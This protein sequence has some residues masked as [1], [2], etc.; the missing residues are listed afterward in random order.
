MTRIA[1]MRHYPTDW[2]DEARLQGQ[3]DRPLTEAGR[4]RIAALSLPPEWAGA[5][6]ISSTLSRAVDTAELM[7]GR[8]PERE[9][10][11]VEIAWGDWEGARSEDLLKDPASGFVPTH[12]M[13]WDMRPP[14]GE[15]MRDA[16]ER[17]RPA[18]ADVAAAG[19]PA[20][21]VIHKALMRMLFGFAHNW[22]DAPEVKRGRIYPMS[23]RASG[24]PHAPEP[25]VPLIER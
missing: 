24:M 16:W 1:L 21:L 5:R 2:N 19:E 6:L 22:R 15:S 9:P 20:V 3:I 12:E 7:T 23:L 17:V 11:L 25:P 13:S 18:L 4:T 10:R 8:A 14:G